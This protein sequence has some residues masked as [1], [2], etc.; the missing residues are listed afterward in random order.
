MKPLVQAKNLRKEFYLSKRNI[1]TAI[2]DVSFDIFK[3]ETLGLVGES[4]CGKS[5]LGRCL[6]RLEDPT[7]GEVLFEG[8][9]IFTFSRTELFSFRRKVQMIFQ[10][11]YTAL[12]PRMTAEDIIAE[13]MRIHSIFSEESK[14]QIDG[15][16]DRVGLSRSSKGRFPHEFSGGQRQRIVI[17]RALTLKP[18]LLICDEPMSALDVS[19]QAQI[20]NLLKDLQ[21]EFGL[22]Y[23]FISHDLP[24]VKYMSDRVIVMQQGKFVEMGST[25]ELFS[26][27]V[28]AYTKELLSAIPTADPRV[29]K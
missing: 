20:A 28:H 23:F 13:P 1:L 2:E 7:K 3:G 11:P 26:N 10:D 8:H 14:K 18:Q 29:K 21:K 15:F 24:M 16:F 27:P 22:T 25:N 5:T 19:V 17:A 6:L 9:N 4:G 12:N